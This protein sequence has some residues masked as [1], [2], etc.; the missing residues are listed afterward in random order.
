MIFILNEGLNFNPNNQNI[1]YYL[2]LAYYKIG[3]YNK[4]IHFLKDYYLS[5]SSDLTAVYTMG[6]AYFYNQ[7]YKNAFK[8]LSIA[9][10]NDDY[11]ILYYLGAC[12]YHLENYR[13]AIPFYKKSLIINPQNSYAIYLLGQTYI[14]LGNKKEAKRQLK[15]LTDLDTILFETLKLSFNTKFDL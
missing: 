11:E 10:S 5:N 12:Q 14:V 15:L 13:K 6:M 8:Y 7:D 4:S 2:G 3:F 9:N 1:I